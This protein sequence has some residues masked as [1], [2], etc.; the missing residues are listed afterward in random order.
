VGYYLDKWL[1]TKG[2]FVTIFIVLGVIGGATVVY[3]QI[4]EIIG[5]ND[6]DKESSGNGV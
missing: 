2:V 5:K 6:N 3:R 4:M 1:D